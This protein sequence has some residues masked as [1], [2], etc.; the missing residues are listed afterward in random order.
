MI[1]TALKTNSKGRNGTRN[2]CR[3]HH[4]RDLVIANTESIA[5]VQPGVT[6]T[7]RG[8]YVTGGVRRNSLQQVWGQL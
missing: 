2:A 5:V 6:P 4:G 7:N 8:S 3:T 1:D